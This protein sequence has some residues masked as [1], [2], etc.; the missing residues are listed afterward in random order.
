MESRWCYL[1]NN[2]IGYVETIGSDKPNGDLCQVS[3]EI[4]TLLH[5]SFNFIKEN[6]NTLY[7]E[8]TWSDLGDIETVSPYHELIVVKGYYLVFNISIEGNFNDDGHTEEI[9]TKKKKK[10]KISLLC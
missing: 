7:S 2:R 5:D 3:L 10:K 9:K 4:G 8:S 6:I 1:R